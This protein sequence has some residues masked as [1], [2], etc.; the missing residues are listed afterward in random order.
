MSAFGSL[1]SGKHRDLMG[2]DI[3]SSSV[4]LLEL[5]RRGDQYAIEAFALEPLPAYAVVDNQIAEPKAVAEAIQRAVSRA[6]TRTR[7]AAV[8]VAGSSV[9]TKQISLPAGLREQ[10]MEDQIK[11][12]ADQYI[13]Y[14]ID[15]VNLDFQVVGEGESGDGASVDVLLAACR[16]DQI[17]SRVAAL[18]I[19]GL[20]PR[21]VDIEAYAL[22]NACQF[23]TQQMPDRGRDVTVA[24]VDIGSNTTSM[25]VLQDLTTVYTRDQ[26]FGG[27][28]LTEEIMR[29]YGL[30]Y[31][32]A[33]RAKRRNEL[34]DDYESGVLARFVD[35]MAQQ[36]DRSLQFFYASPGR[37]DVVAQLILAGG[38]A[39]IG[40]VAEAIQERLSIPTVIARPFAGLSVAPRA[41]PQQLA[42]EEASMMIAAGLALRSFDAVD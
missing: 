5:S 3:S 18:E 24:L 40:G 1:F 8:A 10:D 37:H 35:D 25:L 13:P 31:D 17:E 41:R 14:P 19:A 22:E 36:I 23:L 16:K 28:Q 4:K 20:T 9:I 30:S 12:E 32:E 2:L 34:P 7:D 15:Q 21:V 38:C 26:A 33:G 39:Q 29:Q 11:A 27:K 6:G 42:R